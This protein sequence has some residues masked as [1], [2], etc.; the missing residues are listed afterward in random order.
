LYFIAY[1]YAIIH[2]NS[3]LIAQ[4]C[5]LIAQKCSLIAQK[6]SLIA[7]KQRFLI[8]IVLS[9]C[10]FVPILPKKGKKLGNERTFLDNDETILINEGEL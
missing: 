10:I 4:K 7:Q 3:S 8:K 6:R 5:S 1:E 2:R 9:F